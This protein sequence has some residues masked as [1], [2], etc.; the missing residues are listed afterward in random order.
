MNR[1]LTE[2]PPLPPPEERLDEL[3]RLIEILADDF[4]DYD[5][6][7]VYD[8]IFRSRVDSMMEE[9]MKDND[10]E[11]YHLQVFGQYIQETNSN[12]ARDFL[13]FFRMVVVLM[14]SI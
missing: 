3:K 5:H 8:S 10:E 6:L 12:R 9:I 4:I 2:A 11:V 13:K 7:Y 14:E 1:K